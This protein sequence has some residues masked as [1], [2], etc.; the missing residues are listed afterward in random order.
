MLHHKQ[1]RC[2][3]GVMY[4]VSKAR[5]AA[6]VPIAKGKGFTEVKVGGNWIPIDQHA[7]KAHGGPRGDKR[8]RDSSIP[9]RHRPRQKLILAA[10]SQVLETTPA[11]FP[12]HVAWC[13]FSVSSA[14]AFLVNLADDK[15]RK[16]AAKAGQSINM[17]EINERQASTDG[18]I[19]FMVPRYSRWLSRVPE[20]ARSREHEANSGTLHM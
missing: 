11:P 19:A 6:D 14:T 3:M 17:M 2:I 10:R 15:A 16:V 12:G 7:P 4:H 13:R 8:P 9:A 5:T 20:R 18:T 1:K